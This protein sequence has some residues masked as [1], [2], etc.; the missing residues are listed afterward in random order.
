MA[1]ETSTLRVGT[2]DYHVRSLRDR[3]Q[4]WDG[5]Q[6]SAEAG[7]SSASWP[8][9]GVLW[10]SGRALAEEMCEFPIT[11]KRILEVGCGIGLCSMVLQQRGADITA[12]DY[13]P[14]AEEFLRHNTDLNGLLP[15]HFQQAPWAGPNPELG[16]FD[17]IVGS[18]LLYERGHPAL[19]A[20]FLAC[21]AKPI[22]Q[23]ILTDPGRTHCGQFSTKMAEQ[24]YTRTERRRHFTGS[25]LR[26][27]RGRIMSFIRGEV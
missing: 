26:T 14:V 4:F 15:I 6:R 17:L 12:S 13:H 22:A 10:P 8:L 16:R 24:G 20:E 11:G 25:D 5:D 18:D 7:I 1:V 9:F 23:I 2:H 19:L 3:Q 21:H 27:S